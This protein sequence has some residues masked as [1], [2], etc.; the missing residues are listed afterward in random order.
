MG[1]GGIVP[2]SERP[3]VTYALWRLLLICVAA[4]AGETIAYQLEWYDI[5]MWV[6]LF[7]GAAIYI[8]TQGLDTP[9]PPS[10]RRGEIKYWRGR[11]VDDDDRPRRLN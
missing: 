9:R 11:R 5:V 6:G 4:A 3:I 2:A 1:K 7:C 10:G 8:F